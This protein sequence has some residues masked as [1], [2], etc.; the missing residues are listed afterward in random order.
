MTLATATSTVQIAILGPEENPRAD[1]RGCALW[2]P[3]YAPAVSQAGGTPVMVGEAQAGKHWSEVLDGIDGVVFTGNSKL[4]TQA[5]LEE[6]RLC[7]WCRKHGVPLLAVDH[8]MHLLNQ[9][10][11]GTIFLEVGKEVPEALQHR[12]PPEPGVRHA[13]NVYRDTM[14]AGLYGE[15]EIVVNSEHSRALDRVAR[16]FRVS[17]RA[18][19]GVVEAIE[20]EDEDWFA[21]GVQW[22]PAASSASGLDIQLFRGLIDACKAK[23]MG[24]LG[25]SQAA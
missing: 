2:A 23:S 14:L 1:F 9:A 8:G 20:T 12:H 10:F 25:L 18:L 7:K 16:G 13:I 5:R 19:D 4:T 24:S 15:G 6:E 21:M 22:R 17:A 3:G 11:G